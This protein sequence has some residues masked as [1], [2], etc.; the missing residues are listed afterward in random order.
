MAPC[1][2]A[3]HRTTRPARGFP[4]PFESSVKFSLEK[5]RDFAGSPRH[6]PVDADGPPS[7]RLVI[8]GKGSAEFIANLLVVGRNNDNRFVGIRQI[9]GTRSNFYLAVRVSGIPRQ[10]SVDS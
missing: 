8:G 9:D 3:A 5:A 4:G 2:T 1:P 6:S 7:A 10:K